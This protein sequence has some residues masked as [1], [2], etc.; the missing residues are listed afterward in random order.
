MIYVVRLNQDS[1]RLMASRRFKSKI[2]RWLL[3][4][5]ILVV[6]VEVVAVIEFVLGSINP[7]AT[8]GL[9]LASLLLIALIVSIA[10]GTHYTIDRSILKIVSGP[11]RWQVPI[12]QINA[13]EATRNPLSSPA[14]SLDRIRIRY[15]KGR[16]ILVSPADR[17]GFLRAIGQTLSQ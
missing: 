9:I 16:K 6:I 1:L 10:V 15:G 7:L 8:T 17:D 3:G 13:V 11:F 14:M 2:D 12:D 4:V 5:L